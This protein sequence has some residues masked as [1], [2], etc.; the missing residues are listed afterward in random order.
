MYL[1]DMSSR[2]LSPT[3]RVILGFLR[4]SPRTGYDIKS[5]IEIS[6]RFFWGASYGQIYPELKRLERSG[7]VASEASPR[8]ARKRMVYRLTAAGEKAL[9]EWLTDRESWIFEY[10]DEWV[11]RLFFGDLIP[12]EESLANV[13]AARGF[14]TETARFFRAELEPHARGDA[15]EGAQFPLLALEFG[16][17]FLEWAAAWY[18]DV[19]RRLS[20]QA[21]APRARPA[22]SPAQDPR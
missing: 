8:G 9:D 17:G 5:V 2:D 18:A 3:A 1:A 10:R 11:L 16:V 13:Q 15:E 12:L 19:E 4:F 6:T 21:R 20:R 14:F 7:L 22:E